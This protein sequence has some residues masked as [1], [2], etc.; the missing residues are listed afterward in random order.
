MT[1]EKKFPYFG[2]W[3]IWASQGTLAWMVQTIIQTISKRGKKGVWKVTDLMESE[4]GESANLT[5]CAGR[6]GVQGGF[7]DLNSKNSWTVTQ[8][9]FS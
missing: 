8:D 3:G 7:R 5:V 1:Q 6:R 2:T 9:T 4:G